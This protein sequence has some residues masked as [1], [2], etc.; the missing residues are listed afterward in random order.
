ME[1]ANKKGFKSI[2]E[3]REEIKPKKPAN[4]EYWRTLLAAKQILSKLTIRPFFIIIPI[5]LSFLSAMCEGLSLALL[6]PL[7]KGLLDKNFDFIQRVPVLGVVVEK[8]S[9]LYDAAFFHTFTLIIIVIIFFAILKEVLHYASSIMIT[10]RQGLLSTELKHK[11]MER[12]LGFGKF[13][14]DRTMPGYIRTIIGFAKDVTGLLSMVNSV[15]NSIFTLGIY[16]IIMFKASW[17]I[18]LFCLVLF[19]VM[20]FSVNW[21]I[22]R[23]HKTSKEAVKAFEELSVKVYTILSSMHLI[24]AY[25]REE[26]ELKEYR[27]L[28]E[29]N[30]LLGFS[31]AK[32]MGL[33][34][35]IRSTILLIVSLLVLYFIAYLVYV[36]KSKDELAGFLVVF[37]ILRRA[38]GHF[39]VLSDS[40]L[41]LAKQEPKIVRVAEVFDDK[42]KFCVK[43]GQ[44]N[45]SHLKENIKFKNLN[46]SY[47]KGREI[48]KGITF[49]INQGHMTALVGETGV[50]KTTTAHLI[51]RFYDCP[52]N[53]ILIDGVDIRDFNIKSLR[54]NIAL[55]SQDAMLING[56]IKENI[57]FG[58]ENVSEKDLMWAVEKARLFDFIIDLPYGF[59]TMVGDRG[60]QLSGG[61]RQRVSIARALLRK[62]EIL[63]LDEATSSLDSVTEKMIQEAID[64]VVK[65]RTSIVIAHRLSTI[66]H[67][68]KIVVLDKGTVAEEGTL[69]ELIERQGVFY[70]FWQEQKFD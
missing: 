34:F 62:S 20:N 13:Y 29:R 69:E 39:K 42:N 56:T 5:I 52:P 25:T 44:R 43:G 40:R 57:V 50:G 30:R 4:I 10:Y 22:K 70:K 1:Q 16:L 9:N 18:S 64:E 2:F 11:M 12:Y 31:M 36:G 3:L 27:A 41:T 28:N 55:V 7:A 59:K 48:L 60:V 46:F 67:A 61:E 33:V 65:N 53:S 49:A 63:V 21:L 47:V 45:F 35:P 38:G 23:I 66:K 14:F 8:I 58:A 15:L 26:Q 24:K 19:P 17:K 6:A 51:L 32:K 68:D 54:R 37:F